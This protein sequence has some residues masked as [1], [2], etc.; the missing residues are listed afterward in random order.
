MGACWSWTPLRNWKKLVSCCLYWKEKID[1]H[2]TWCPATAR[3]A[4]FQCSNSWF[5]P[6]KWT[7]KCSSS[8][9]LCVFHKVVLN[10]CMWHFFNQKY[11]AVNIFKFNF[12][13]N[14][15]N[16]FHFEWMVEWMFNHSQ[17]KKHLGC[18]QFVAITNK[19]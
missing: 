13:K 2:Y 16:I 8:V 5:N 15:M 4:S 19:V 14:G 1:T 9:T 7:T 10:K 3:K 12:L 11:Y 18:F 6:Q 17:V